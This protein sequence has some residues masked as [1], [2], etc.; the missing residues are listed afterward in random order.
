M[1]RRAR[2]HMALGLAPASGHRSTRLTLTSAYF[3][4]TGT[5]ALGV[6]VGGVLAGLAGFAPA[7]AAIASR[8]LVVL[9]AAASSLGLLMTG[10]DLRKKRRRGGIA[11]VAALLFPVA[12]SLLSQSAVATSVAITSAVGLGMLLTV[13][14]ELR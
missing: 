13:W 8:P 2:K 3:I 7:A 4:W 11:A 1:I 5:L 6:T 14:T 12:A 9:V 10:V